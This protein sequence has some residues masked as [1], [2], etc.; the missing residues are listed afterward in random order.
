VGESLS[1]HPKKLRKAI[2]K[3]TIPCS[4]A[5]LGCVLIKRKV[6]EVIQFRMEWPEQGGH[7]DSYFSRDVLRAGFT[8]KADMS[9]ICGHK[10]ETGEIL[11]PEYPSL[12]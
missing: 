1:L 8:Q 4:G 5:G 6:L 3:G 12:S 11:W 10:T 9:V 2:Q 7:C